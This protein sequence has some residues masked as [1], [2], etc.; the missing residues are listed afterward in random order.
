MADRDPPRRTLGAADPR[1]ARQVRTSATL[2]G[3]VAPWVA[4][5]IALT[6][7]GAVIHVLQL[8]ALGRL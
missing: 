8:R 6:A 7:G 4:A 5:M 3:W 1:D 2:P